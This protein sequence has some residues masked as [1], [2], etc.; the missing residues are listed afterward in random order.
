M[1]PLTDSSYDSLENELDNSSGGSPGFCSRGV[2]PSKPLRGSQ[3]SIL[4]FSDCDQD[5]DPRHAQAVP[6]TDTSS[7]LDSLCL[8]G[9]QRQRRRSEPAIA[10]VAKLQPCVRGSTEGLAGEEHVSKK[11]SG[12]TRRGGGVS[13]RCAALEASCS[14]LSSTPTSPAPMCSS[15]DSLDSLGTDHTCAT[16]R[17]TGWSKMHLPS[18]CTSSAPVTFNSAS[19]SSGS[20][21]LGT[22]PKDS[23]PKE[24]LSWGTLKGCR[25]LH[26]NS[27]L[28]KDRRLSLTQQ[29]N[30]EKEEDDKTGVSEVSTVKCWM[31]VVMVIE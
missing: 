6:T 12:Q 20:P 1:Y 28:R 16:G 29:E 5:T 23:P 7:T 4:T 24:P 25:G 14:S 19:P 8:D 26:P 13:G 31:Y 18:D 17:G 27:W 10:Y 22:A 9:L 3:D 2:L 15:P 11:P 30:L 21:D